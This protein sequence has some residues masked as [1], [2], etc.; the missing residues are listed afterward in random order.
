MLIP[1]HRMVFALRGGEVVEL[2]AGTTA[3]TFG[4]YRGLPES[5]HG[6]IAWPNTVLLTG[7]AG[8]VVVDPGYAT[9]GDML[10][11]ALRARGIEP[12]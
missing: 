10:A 6:M 5:V 12:A 8:P 3:G 7:D 4:A 9:Q 2:R 11:G 1:A